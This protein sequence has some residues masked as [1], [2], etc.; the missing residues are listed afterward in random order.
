M[1]RDGSGV[2]SAPPG[3]TATTLTSISSSS[4]NSFVND[5]VTDANTVRPVSA[6]GTGAAT[7]DG[8]LTNLG[9]TAT[10]K[11]VLTA[12]SPAAARTAIGAELPAGAYGLFFMATAPSGWLKANG[13]AVSRTTYA[14]LFA[15]IGTA[16][17]PGD[18]STTFNLPD[19][20]GEFARAWDDSR[21]V[22]AGRA[23]GTSQAAAMLN[24]THTGTTSADGAHNHN[25]TI[26]SGVGATATFQTTS[27]TTATNTSLIAATG[28]H[29]HTVTTG[30]PSAGGGT[31]TR[32][33]NIALLACIKY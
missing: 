21:G 12:A 29:T 27:G 19:M 30:D 4:Y 26:A 1:P 25:A 17:G 31:E 24:H 20:R 23:I 11:A 13:Q 3:T 10:G 18:G 2:Y 6:G 28:T 5:L 14:T 22:D 7:P 32:P 33:R 9:A 15:A 16:Y 8:A